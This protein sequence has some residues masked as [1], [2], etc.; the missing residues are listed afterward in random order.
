MEFLCQFI[1]ILH[2]VQT[3]RHTDE[4]NVTYPHERKMIVAPNLLIICNTN[5]GGPTISRRDVPCWREGCPPPDVTT[6]RTICPN[7][8]I[9]TL[10]P[11][12]PS[13]TGTKVSL[14]LINTLHSIH[15]LGHESIKFN[16]LVFLK[17][18]FGTNR[19]CD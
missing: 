7:E 1:Q 10:I 17:M 12:D 18:A 3:L 6:F 4:T 5:S 11:L 8:R 14:R 16:N 2:L 15:L 19:S 13:I 9:E